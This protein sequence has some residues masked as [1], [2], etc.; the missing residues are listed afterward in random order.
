MRGALSRFVNVAVH[1]QELMD[2]QQCTVKM[3]TSCKFLGVY[4]NDIFHG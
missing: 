4:L 3:T 1:F 2:I